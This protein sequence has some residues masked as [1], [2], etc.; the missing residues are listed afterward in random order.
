MTE[1]WTSLLVAFVLLFGAGVALA[2]DPVAVIT[3]IHPAGGEILI[4]A[5]DDADWKAPK[6]LLA[7]RPGDAVRV[8]GGGRVVIVMTAGR[9]SQTVTQANSPFTIG[10]GAG[11][12]ASDRSRGVVSTVT[13]F[14]AGQQRERSK[15]AVL[16]LATRDIPF[17]ILGPRAT[18]ILSGRPI[19]EWTGPWSVRYRI[20]L[21]GPQ[22][23]VWEQDELALAPLHYPPSAPALSPGTKYRWELDAPKT[24]R[25]RAQQAEFEVVNA[26]DDRRIRSALDSLTPQRTPGYPSSTLVVIRAGLLLQEGLV[27]DARREVV[28]AVAKQDEAT[29]QQLL[30]R[31]YERIGLDRLAEDAFERA[32]A[33]AAGSER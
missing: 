18:G 5:A 28:A 3:E 8:A 22:G 10:G 15:S 14:L 21:H 32:E 17:A 13:A 4:K 2:A 26:A 11:E 29:L 23:L 24:P 30:G 9:G 27:N 31:V 12:G 25:L 7:L 1:R 19:F 6:P 20:K 33:L 16:S